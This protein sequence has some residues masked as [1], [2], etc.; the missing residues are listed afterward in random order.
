MRDRGWAGHDRCLR[1]D[2]GVALGIGALADDRKVGACGAKR[3]EQAV[4]VAPYPTSV[5][6]HGGR[7]DQHS[8][9]HERLPPRLISMSVSLRISA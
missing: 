8:G 4:D 9:G 1:R 2:L 3:A 6:G 5:G 7:V